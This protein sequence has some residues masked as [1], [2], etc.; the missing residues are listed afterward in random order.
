MFVTVQFPMADLRPFVAGTGRLDVP[1][2]PLAEPSRHFVRSLGGVHKRRRG[3]IDEWV[4][5]DVYCNVRNGVHLELA[6]GDFQQIG[7]RPLWK[8][9]Y[10]TGGLRWSGVVARLDVG[11]AARLPRSL[12]AGIRSVRARNLADLSI[13]I[14]T[15]VSSAPGKRAPLGACG[16]RV[17]DLLLLATTRHAASAERESWWLAP[18][19]PIALVEIPSADGPAGPTVAVQELATLRLEGA[20][21]PLWILHYRPGLDRGELRRL[22]IHLWRL[23]QEREVLKIVLRACLARRLDPAA[24]PGLRDYLA[25]QSKRLGKMRADGFPQRE[26]LNRAYRMDAL[27][28]PGELVTLKRMLGDLGPGLMH[29]VTSVAGPF[30]DGEPARSGRFLFQQIGGKIVVQDG[31]QHIEV[32]GGSSVGNIVGGNVE[33][34]SLHAIQNATDSWMSFTAGHDMGRLAQELSELRA[35]LKSRAVEPA[36]DI[37]VAEVAQAELALTAG[38]PEEARTALQKAG[39]WALGIATSIGAT[40]AAAA[41]K[42]AAGI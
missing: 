33:N 12:P 4:G 23:H 40:V 26:L 35:S 10:V 18:G 11:F 41:I 2:W 14:P 7:L 1:P 32:D 22:R 38:K 9:M 42:A 19:R 34:S 5:E 39:T 27:V 8:R 28:D 3:G 24:D 25:G 37:V 15:S 20:E 16:R 17:A 29:S 13:N 30:G 6:P 21:L 36:H 31:G